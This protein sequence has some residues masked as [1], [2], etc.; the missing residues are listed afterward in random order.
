MREAEELQFSSAFFCRDCLLPGQAA[1]R[2]GEEGGHAGGVH[3]NLRV[4][5]TLAF[6]QELL[7]ELWRWLSRSVPARLNPTPPLPGPFIPHYSQTSNDPGGQPLH[8]TTA[9]APRRPAPLHCRTDHQVSAEFPLADSGPGAGR[10]VWVSPTLTGG[11]ASLRPECVA[12][13]GLFASAYDHLLF[14]LDDEEFYSLQKPFSLSEQRAIAAAMNT[15]VVCTY[16]NR[17]ARR[18]HPVCPRASC[19]LLWGGWRG[20]LVSVVYPHLTRAWVVRR[21]IYSQAAAARLPR[22]LQATLAAVTRLMKALYTRDCRKAFCPKGLWLV[23]AP[24]A[25][26]T[27][28]AAHAHAQAAA[29]GDLHTAAPESIAL[30]PCAASPCASTCRPPP[31]SP[32]WPS[33]PPPVPSPIPASSRRRTA[34]RAGGSSSR[35][36]PTL[37]RSMSG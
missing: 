24:A 8:L 4:L 18:R 5:N 31:R 19:V 37:G 10:G 21:P 7:Q 28:S 36:R 32:P 22:D 35:S 12:A 34:P 17:T 20:G 30:V 26:Q 14:I 23:R 11:V 25:A 9:P 16:M 2:F 13:F 1:G 33:P 3:A 15:V 6:S 29:F 27:R